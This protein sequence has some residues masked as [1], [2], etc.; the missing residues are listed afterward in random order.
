M[1]LA[2]IRCDPYRGMIE[3]KKRGGLFSNPPRYI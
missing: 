2:G 3:N 1:T